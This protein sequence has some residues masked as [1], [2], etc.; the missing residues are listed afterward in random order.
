MPRPSKRALQ[1]KK[2]RTDGKTPT[3]TK[4]IREDQ[5][6]GRKKR[7]SRSIMTRNGKKSKSGKWRNSSPSVCS[8][9]SEE[10]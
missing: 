3:F 4:I 2:Q 1:A 7:K 10:V 9:Y 6:N 8:P 5:G